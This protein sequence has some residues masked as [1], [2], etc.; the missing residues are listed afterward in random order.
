VHNFISTRLTL[1]GA[2]LLV[3]YSLSPLAA[4]SE[5]PAPSEGSYEDQAAIGLEAVIDSYRILRDQRREISERLA[6]LQQAVPPDEEAIANARAA[7]E[8]A[9]KDIEEIKRQN[10]NCSS[11]SGR[12]DKGKG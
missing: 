9:K 1:T 8:N 12:C 10:Y 6:E 4:Q 2:L 5:D 7:E 11:I 3:F